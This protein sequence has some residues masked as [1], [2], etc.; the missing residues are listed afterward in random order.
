MEYELRHFDDVLLRFSADKDSVDPDYRISWVNRNVEHLMPQGFE[1]TPEGLE[2]WVRHRTIPKNRAFVSTFLA[3]SGLSAN[4]PLGIVAVCKGLSLNDCYWIA[5]A[6]SGDTFEKVNLYEN[7]MSRLLAEIAFTGHGSSP[8]AGFSSSPEFTTNGNLPKCWRRIDGKIY[9][10]KGGTTGFANAGMEPYSEY[11]ASDVARAFGVE[12]VSY[13]LHKWKGVLC[14]SCELFTSTERSFVPVANV[15]TGG[16]F[17][18]VADYYSK[19]GGEYSQ[20]LSDM[21]AFDA[22]ICNTDRHFNNFGLLVDA[23]TNEFVAP[24]PLFDHG[25]SLFYQAFGDDWAD[26]ASLCEYASALTPCA[27]DDFFA[28]ARGL[29]TH[30]TKAKVRG[31][32]GFE[33]SLGPRLEFTQKRLGMIQRQI[34][35]RAQLLL[36]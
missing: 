23:R 32:L 9:L 34:R 4:R 17:A 30:E 20:A 19:L 14:S 3:R 28:T 13:G 33:F 35:S 5:E 16:G 31:M 8:R 12:A 6:G 27:Y 15:V 7:P 36:G 24:A 18:A 10:Y 22:L 21:L 11:Y 26:D 25:N 29:M 2:A 1:A